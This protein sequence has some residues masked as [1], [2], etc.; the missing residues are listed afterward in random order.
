[1]PAPETVVACDDDDCDE[2]ERLRGGMTADD[3]VDA[4]VVLWIKE[5]RRTG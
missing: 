1:M 3:S 2:A 5:P 4:T